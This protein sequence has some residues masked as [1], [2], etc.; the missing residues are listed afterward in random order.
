MEQFKRIARRFIS[1]V[2]SFKRLL[3]SLDFCRFLNFNVIVFRMF[4]VLFVSYRI[5]CSVFYFYVLM[6]VVCSMY[7]LVPLISLV[8]QLFTAV[9]M[10]EINKI[11]SFECLLSEH[12]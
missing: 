7:L 1:S 12:Y 2:Q 6:S 11:H 10:N 3:N 4:Y 9:N 8:L 5:R